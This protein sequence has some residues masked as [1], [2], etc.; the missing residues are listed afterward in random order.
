MSQTF[1]ATRSE[2][3][4]ATHTDSKRTERSHDKAVTLR[5]SRHTKNLDQHLAGRAFKRLMREVNGR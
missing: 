4:M 2:N 1:T 5:V 3:I